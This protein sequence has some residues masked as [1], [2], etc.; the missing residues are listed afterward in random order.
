MNLKS[1]E[2]YKYL[3]YTQNTKNN[4]DDH[5]K[6]VKGRTE[7]AYQQMMALAGNSNFEN[8][9]ME[10]IWTVLKACITPAITYSGEAWEPTRKNY[11]GANQIID[12]VLKRILKTPTHRT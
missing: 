10:T 7:A 6:T 11:Q 1:T 9:E 12:N 4:N 5:I 8:V 2:K 3:G